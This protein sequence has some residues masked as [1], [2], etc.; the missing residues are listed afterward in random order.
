MNEKETAQKIAASAFSQ[1]Y[2]NDL[3]YSVFEKLSEAGF[4]YDPVER[5]QSQELHMYMHVQLALQSYNEV[6]F[7]IL[8]TNTGL[9]LPRKFYSQ[10]TSE[11]S[12]LSFPKAH[13]Q[14]VG[15]E[16][17]NVANVLS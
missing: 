12:G 2:L 10:C 4:F 11:Y 6:L 17:G 13:F 16:P 1:S 14:T 8:S 7:T 3:V 9:S 15:P 5:G